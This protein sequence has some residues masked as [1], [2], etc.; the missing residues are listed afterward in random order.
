MS[1]KMTGFSC[2]DAQALYRM[3]R[4]GTG[5]AIVPAFLATEDEDAASQQIEFVLPDW[6]L[7]PIEVYA[8]WPT[9]APRHGLIKLLVGALSDGVARF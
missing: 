7:N 2:N 3:A 6:E 8:Q 9:N 1:R 4:A 5:I